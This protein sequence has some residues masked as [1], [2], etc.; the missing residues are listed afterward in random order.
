MPHAATPIVETK[1]NPDPG[2]KSIRVTPNQAA[3]LLSCHPATVRKLVGEGLF[4][5]IPSRRGER[6]V[7]KRYFLLREEV[8]VFAEG[9]EE[10][11][12]EYRAKKKSARKAASA[13]GG[14][15]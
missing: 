5:V 12:R 10:V 2:E 9:G 6:G 7:G 13:K 15:R 11:L 8:E 3:E 14:R 1:T 4:S